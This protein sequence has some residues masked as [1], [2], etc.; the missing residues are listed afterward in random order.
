MENKIKDIIKEFSNPREEVL[1]EAV[2]RICSL[3]D[4]SERYSNEIDT[5]YVF[6]EVDFEYSEYIKGIG[7]EYNYV[8]NKI[9]Y[10]I[11]GELVKILNVC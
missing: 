1:N 2:K 6:N 4:V 10:F 3:F 8:S 5:N 7:K 11:N 9:H